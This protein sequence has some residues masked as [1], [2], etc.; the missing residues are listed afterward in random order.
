MYTRPWRIAVFCVLFHLLV[1]VVLAEC[2]AHRTLSSMR[3]K[4]RFVHQLDVSVQRYCWATNFNTAFWASSSAP[5]SNSL[6]THLTEHVRFFNA[7]FEDFARVLRSKYPFHHLQ[8]VSPTAFVAHSGGNRRANA[9]CYTL[10]IVDTT[11][12]AAIWKH[13]L[14]YKLAADSAATRLR[15]RARQDINPRS[16]FLNQQ[17]C[18]WPGIYPTASSVH[19]NDRLLKCAE[20]SAL[21]I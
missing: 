7:A 13:M 1:F 12:S 14:Q 5:V 19:H 8:R 10:L 17:L 4:C 18:C 16:S 20:M 6:P 15:G 3:A 9:T 11:K 2:S 21:G